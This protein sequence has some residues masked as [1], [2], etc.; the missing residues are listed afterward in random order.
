MKNRQI[1]IG[2]KQ[3]MLTYHTEN[4]SFPATRIVFPTITLLKILQKKEDKTEILTFY[5]SVNRLNKP[6]WKQI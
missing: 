6:Q 2:F 1:L 3:N 4:G 5:P